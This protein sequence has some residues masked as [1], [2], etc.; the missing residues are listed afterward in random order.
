MAEEMHKVEEIAGVQIER[1]PSE[2]RLAEL[3]VRSWPTWSCP[4]S[5]IPW[6]FK[7]R[8]TCYLLKGKVKVK[9]NVMDAEFEIGE[10]D[11]LVFPSGMSVIWDVIEGVEKHYS[12]VN[13]EL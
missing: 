12:V 4:P 13:E 7:G 10:G 6:T 11:L 3:G 1:N 2:S 5:K 9:V 8:E